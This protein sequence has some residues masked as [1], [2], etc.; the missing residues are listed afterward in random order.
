MGDLDGRRFVITGASSGIGLEVARRAAARGAAVCLVSRRLG[1]LTEAAQQIGP[2]AWALAADLADPEAATT[3]R[4]AVEARWGGVDGLVNNA[5]IATPGRVEQVD[6]VTWDRLFAVNARAPFLLVRALLP[7]FGDRAS[8]VNVSS[9]LA[10]KPIPGMAAY[11]ASKAA[12]NALTQSL[13]VE[14]APRV[15]VNAI[16]PAV[17]DTPIHET[18]GLS[19]EQVEGMG[20]IHPMGRIGQPEDIAEMVLFLLSDRAA[21]VTGALI[22]VDGG[23]LVT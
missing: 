9:T 15:R 16:M 11:N 12:L 2:Q 19:R 5:G 21:W 1:T 7:L 4:G 8:V 13:A 18:R 20:G 17:I 3:L 23:M 22:P 14:L 10:V 6:A